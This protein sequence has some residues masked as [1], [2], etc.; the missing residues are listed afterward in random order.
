MRDIDPRLDQFRH[1]PT[2]RCWWCGEK[3]TTR[4]H[5]FKHSDLRRVATKDGARDLSNLFKRSDYHAGPLRT[6][7]R[8]DEVQ[9]GMNLCAPCNNVKSQPF[10]RAYDEFLKYMFMHGDDL[11][12]RET[13]DWA[14]VYGSDWQPKTANL[15]RYFVKQFSCMMATQRLDVTQHAI[16]FLNGDPRCP[17]IGLGLWRDHRVIQFHKALKRQAD[18][19]EGM[20]HFVGLPPTYALSDGAKI[21]GSDY[22]CRLGYLTFDVAWRSG[23][24]MLS[25]HEVRLIQLPLINARIRDQLAWFPVQAQSLAYRVRRHL[26]RD[27]AE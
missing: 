5:K 9:W 25:F 2:D 18:D 24:D 20:L 8:G 4:E 3:A 13:L 15:A 6:L 26:A 10:D 27:R 17:S 1:G 12:E 11:C 21:T 22:Q 7:K 19:P 16:D 14:D 23:A